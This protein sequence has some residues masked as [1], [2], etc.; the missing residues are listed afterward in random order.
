VCEEVTGLDLKVC[1]LTPILEVLGSAHMQQTRLQQHLGVYK[2]RGWPPLVTRVLLHQ[3]SEAKVH[4]AS[5]AGPM[6]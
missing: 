6:G 4:R 1:F 3:E 5:T 2:Y